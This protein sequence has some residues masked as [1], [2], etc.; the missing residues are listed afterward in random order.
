MALDLAAFRN[1][2]PEF[3][4]TVTDPR[5]QQ[6]LIESLDD[7]DATDSKL[8]RLQG[9]IT[10]HKCFVSVPSNMLASNVKQTRT[11]DYS[12]TFQSSSELVALYPMIRAATVNYYARS[13]YGIEYMYQAYSKSVSSTGYVV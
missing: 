8:D 12:T 2:Y 6:Y 3:N 7:I 11:S 9:L 1:L 13:S 4:D 5:V 10:A